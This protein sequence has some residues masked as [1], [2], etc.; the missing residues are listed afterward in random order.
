MAR[1]TGALEYY[2]NLVLMYHPKRIAFRYV[3]HLCVDSNTSRSQA[4]SMLIFLNSNE[5]F[6]ACTLLAAIDHN[7]HL[8]REVL[9]DGE[10][11]ALYDRI[12]RR[13]TKEW[14]VMPRKEEKGYNYVPGMIIQSFTE[15]ARVNLFV[16]LWLLCQRVIQLASR[17]TLLCAHPSLLL[18]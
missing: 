16:R 15:H 3:S 12:Y 18:R 13:Q 6:R 14:N 8:D 5:A 4:T 7:H 1:H 17:L 11:K 2:H 9:T 10:E